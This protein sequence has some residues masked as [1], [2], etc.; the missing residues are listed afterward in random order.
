MIGGLQGLF[1][2]MAASISDRLWSQHIAEIAEAAVP[3]RVRA[4]CT[5]KEPERMIWG[6]IIG[7][8]FG[9]VFYTMRLGGV[10]LMRDAQEG[11]HFVVIQAALHALTPAVIG[12]PIGW[13][14]A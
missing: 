5:T 6:A 4:R 13:A 7:A 11:I 12:A 3:N 9:V 1:W 14:L 2:A 10:L 8:I